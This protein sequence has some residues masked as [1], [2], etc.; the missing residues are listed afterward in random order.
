MPQN[1]K[2]KKSEIEFNNENE[3][4][5]VYTTIYEHNPPIET[6]FLLSATVI[7]GGSVSTQ[8]ELRDVIKTANEPTS[9][10]CNS[11]PKGK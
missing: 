7:N 3:S 6:I 11:G 4:L 9:F 8:N 5:C 2:R 10:Y 1:W